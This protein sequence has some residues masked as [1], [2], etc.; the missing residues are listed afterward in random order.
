MAKIFWIAEKDGDSME[1]WAFNNQRKAN[2]KAM[3]LSSDFSFGDSEVA[4]DGNEDGDAF[5]YSGTID[6]KDCFLLY[7]M[8]G[9]PHA[10]GFNSEDEA[11]DAYP[12]DGAGACFSVKLKGG[13]GSVYMSTEAEGDGTELWIFEDGDIY[14]NKK[15]KIMKHVKLFEAFVASQ[16]VKGTAAADKIKKSKVNEDTDWDACSLAQKDKWGPV[17]KL[18]K[19]DYNDLVFF[20]LIHNELDEYTEEEYEYASE[21]DE[22]LDFNIKKYKLDSINSED[23]HGRCEGAVVGIKGTKLKY[24]W[25]DAPD[26]QY[27]GT[28]ASSKD[29]QALEDFYLDGYDGQRSKAIQYATP[30]YDVY[31]EYCSDMGFEL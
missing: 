20:E 14:E 31:D 11:R 2:D 3:E 18:L 19:C 21:K 27:S 22:T 23:P 28:I 12:G 13:M 10:K 7:R 15:T 17:C 30:M 26:M 24:A 16:K 4:K 29:L 9:L 8:D 25:F 6:A 5:F 1:M